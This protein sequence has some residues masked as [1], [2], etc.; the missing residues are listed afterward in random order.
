M[1][2]Y[3]FEIETHIDSIDILDKVGKEVVMNFATNY[4]NNKT[5]YTD[6]NGLEEQTRI[7]N[8]RPTWPLVVNEEVAGNYYPVNSHIGLEDINTKKKLTIVTDRS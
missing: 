4:A 3:G 7:L 1:N 5:F 6:S 8:Y 2:K